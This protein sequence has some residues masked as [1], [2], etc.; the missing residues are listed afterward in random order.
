M[1]DDLFGTW[2]LLGERSRYEWGPRPRAGRYTI[3]RAGEGA[4][5]GLAWIDWQ[6]AYKETGFELG[7]DGPVR[8]ARPDARTLDSEVWQ[9]DLLSAHARRT[10]AADGRHLHVTWSGTT[11]DGLP[12]TNTQLYR[13]G[14][15]DEPLR[16][17]PLVVAVA[18]PYSAPDAAGR[19]ANLRRLEAAAAEI[20]ARGHLP[21]VGVSAALPL[22]RAWPEPEDAPDPPERARQILGI[23]LAVVRDADAIVHLASSPG[24]DRE[25]DLLAALGRPVL[26]SA[27]ELPA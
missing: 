15:R 8:L 22:V 20:A 19:R 2:I 12:F 18:G 3:G 10:L 21:L 7:F 23:S 17:I 25:R 6:G 16:A 1:H 11:P 4:R 13:R 9:G 27:D 24:A 14:D 5:F 26:S